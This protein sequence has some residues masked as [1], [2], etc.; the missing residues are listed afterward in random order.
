M[1]DLR[2]PAK[3]ADPR[4]E[5]FLQQDCAQWLKKELYLRGLPQV[6]YHCP[7]ERKATPAQHNRLKLQGV[8]SGVSDV[9]LPLKSEGFCG[10]YCEL[11]TTTG[12]PSP[13][14]KQFLKDVAAEG[15]LALVVNDLAT[16]KACF[17]KY[18]NNRIK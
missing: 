14:Q 2:K 15:Y 8:L 1:I 11:K 4:K 16:F 9:V 10:V 3:L 18:L 13:E 12:R 6:F 5:H 7:N 17:T